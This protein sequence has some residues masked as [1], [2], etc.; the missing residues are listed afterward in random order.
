[1]KARTTVDRWDVDSW[2]L[3][4][5]V[6]SV[7]CSLESYVWATTMHLQ[8]PDRCNQNHH[9]WL[10]ARGPAFNVE[11][12]LHPDVGPETSFRHCQQTRFLRK[13]KAKKKDTQTNDNKIIKVTCKYFIQT[14]SSATNPELLK[15]RKKR[16]DRAP[17]F[18]NEKLEWKM[19]SQGF[20]RARGP[21]IRP[22]LHTGPLNGFQ[23]K[24]IVHL[25]WRP[26]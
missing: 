22:A 25:E 16:K 5:L 24:Q 12:L 2:I 18:W 14:I 21:L 15:C 23:T 11:E 13:N 1:M 9:I 6:Y 8:R 17:V 3:K 7:V 20:C 4:V 10:Q 19:G 26:C